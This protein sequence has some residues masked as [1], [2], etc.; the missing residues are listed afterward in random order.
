MEADAVPAIEGAPELLA[1]GALAGGSRR[2]REW[3]APQLNFAESVPEPVRALL[4]DAMTSG[5]LLVATPAE[6][7]HDMEQA[8]AAA[9]PESARIGTLQKG[10]PGQ[11]AVV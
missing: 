10:P 4:C 5:G 3:L 6:R 8:L 2:N 1:A 11:I 7:A 9:A